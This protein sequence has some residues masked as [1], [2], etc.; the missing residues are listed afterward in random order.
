MSEPAIRLGLL[1][2]SAASALLGEPSPNV[3]VVRRHHGGSDDDAPFIPAHQVNHHANLQLLIDGGC[4][5]VLSINSVGS[6]R[7]ETPVGSVVAPDDFYAPMVNP[8]IHDDSDGHS[9]PGFHKEWRRTVVETWTSLR[10]V[11]IADGGVYAQTRGP[12]F[13]TPA[14]IRMLA[15]VADVV[16]MTVASECILARELGLAYAAVCVVD[17]LGNGLAPTG[18]DLTLADYETGKADNFAMLAATFPPLVDL[19]LAGPT[20]PQH[21]ETH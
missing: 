7:P 1:L 10:T 2:G 6:L 8:S 15:T 12:R 20:P 21:E 14:E 11:P 18:A 19:L 16:G 17:N 4:S 3:L 5:H 9:V 13:E